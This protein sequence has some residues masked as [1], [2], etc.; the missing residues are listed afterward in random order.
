MEGMIEGTN[1]RMNERT[2]NEQRKKEKEERKEIDN[3]W[4][5]GV[6]YGRKEGQEQRIIIKEGEDQ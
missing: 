1:E 2:N 6:R 3:E 5:K 4:M